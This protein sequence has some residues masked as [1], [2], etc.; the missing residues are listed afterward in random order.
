MATETGAG[1]NGPVVVLGATSGIG[2][3]AVDEALARGLT[4]RGFARGA[5]SLPQRPGLEPVAG[6]A[7][8]PDDLSR[9]LEGAGAVIYALGVKERPAMLWQHETLFSDTT[10]ALL[11]AMAA[12]GV[13]RLVAVT[14]F[15]AGRSRDAMSR[16]ERLGHGAI[17][18]RV[19]DDKSRQEALI[20]ESDTDWTIAR[21]VIL[22]RGARTGKARVLRDP[23]EWRNGL[24]PRA[25]VAAYLV[26]AVTGDMDIRRDVVLAR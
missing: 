22:T 23:S 6:D 4:V 19:Y 3:L 20:M 24:I 2:A 8:T 12:T 18:G 21:P 9:A 7:R 26:D 25:D 13:R 10:A 1:P 14:G 11:D 5:A 16:L 15:G 17:L